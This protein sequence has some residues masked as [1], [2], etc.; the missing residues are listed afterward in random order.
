VSAGNLTAFTLQNITQPLRWQ[1]IKIHAVDMY[2]CSGAAVPVSPL[3]R[4]YVP[5]PTILWDL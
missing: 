5:T 2:D 1:S 3:Q 4:S